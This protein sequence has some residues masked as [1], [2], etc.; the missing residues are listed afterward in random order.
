MGLVSLVTRTRR[1]KGWWSPI[2]LTAFTLYI[3]AL[4]FWAAKPN[5]AIVPLAVAAIVV[6]VLSACA[7]LVVPTPARTCLI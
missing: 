6:N 7:S 3:G 2:F 5:W 1:M 4:P